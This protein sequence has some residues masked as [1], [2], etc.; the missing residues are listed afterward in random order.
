MTMSLDT[1]SR[2]VL[3]SVRALCKDFQRPNGTQFTALEGI[4][5][6]VNDGEFLAVLGLSGSGKSTLLRCM[7]GLVKP[8]RGQVSFAQPPSK[9]QQLVSFVF[10]NFALFPWLTVRENVEV[11]LAHLSRKERQEKADAILGLVNLSGFDD[12]YPRELSGG[13]RQ[14]VSI[15]RAMVCDPMVMFMD[16]PFSALDPLTGESLRA[17]MGRLWM[18]SSRTIR[19]IVLVTHSLQEALQL[20]DR[21]VI[22]S[23]GPGSIYRTIEVPLTRPRN[24]STREYLELEAHLERTFGELHLDKL[25][26]SHYDL[27]TLPVDETLGGGTHAAAGTGASAS[28]GQSPG[29]FRPMRRVKPLINTNLVLVEGLLARLSEEKGAMD[30]Y[31]LADEMGQSVDQMLPAVAS[32]EMLGFINTP[33]TRLVFTELGREYVS[34]QDPQTRQAILRTAVKSLPVVSNLYEVIRGHGEEGLE[35]NIAVEQLVLMLPFEDPEIQFEAM[36]KWARHVDLFSYDSQ[37][38][39]LYVE[40]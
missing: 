36:L 34:E 24:S 14:R 15:A 10:Q 25:T 13:M 9:N 35:K 20:A 4:N 27:Q 28:G 17:E 21:I 12:A 31:D 23:S 2:K 18:Q 32:A 26:G 40:E 30:L 1:P 11:A 6:D 33:G 37:S 22:L 38:E 39:T 16:E 3:I 7:A 5:L 29:T 8:E 19:S